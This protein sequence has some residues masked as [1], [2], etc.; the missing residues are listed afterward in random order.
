LLFWI[1]LDK[2]GPNLQLFDIF[3]PSLNQCSQMKHI[4]SKLIHGLAEN[5]GD[6]NH[7]SLKTPVY[8]TASYDFE[9]AEQVEAAF[10]GESE[11]YV[12]SRITN[13]TVTELE[14][15]LKLLTGAQ[16]CL[17]VS[18]GMA[19]ISNVFLSLCNT[20]DNIIASHYLFGNTYSFFAK[21]L[22]SLGIE[23]RFTGME[24]PHE[25]ES[26][27]DG[28][29][30]ALFM[31]TISNPQLIVFDVPAISAIATK[32]NLPLIVDNSTLSP[33]IFQCR[34]YGVDIEVFSTTKFISGGATSIGGAILMY[35]STKWDTIPKLKPEYANFGDQAFYK[36]L[37]K[38]VYRNMGGCLS[39]GSAFLQLLGLETLALR[40][41]KIS[42]NACM[43]AQHLQ[44]HPLVKRVNYAMLPDSPYHKL[45]RLLLN[46]KA[47]CLIGF[48]LESKSQCFQF[49]NAL[50]MIRRGTNFCDNKSMVIHPAS[51]IYAD[52]NPT[53]KAQMKISEGLIRLAVG[54]EDIE[55][56]LEDIERGLVACNA[57]PTITA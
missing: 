8:N 24:D 12:Y 35:P 2:H 13:P 18:S 27:I 4:S 57:Q 50:T 16:H 36:K 37:F 9:S 39:P 11:A 52:Y 10:R 41:D 34:D 30:R 17:C 47:G 14:T 42:E 20:G 3:T 46:S 48:E 51:T 44:N 15:R 53:E 19:A 49:M 7:R 40:V 29:T 45:T 55:D 23:V 33:Y 56:I 21:T 5:A 54:L 25:V 38:E 31:E 32:H 28:N 1:N 43:V 6:K 22:K 26:L